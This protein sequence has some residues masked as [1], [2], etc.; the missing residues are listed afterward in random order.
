MTLSISVVLGALL[1]FDE[2]LHLAHSVSTM[3][4]TKLVLHVG[5][6]AKA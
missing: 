5:F 4:N 6:G 2:L 3:E 1:A